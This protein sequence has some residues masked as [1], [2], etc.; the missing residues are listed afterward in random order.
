M[1]MNCHK[2]PI[3]H[4]VLLCV[5]S[6]DFDV[7]K[8][9]VFEGPAMNVGERDLTTRRQ[10]GKACI[11]ISFVPHM[12]CIVTASGARWH[13]AMR[14]ATTQVNDIPGAVA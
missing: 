10:F 11:L 3:C 12:C 14:C 1:Q 4:Y 7:S 2:L 5:E 13:R 8:R 9:F 6:H